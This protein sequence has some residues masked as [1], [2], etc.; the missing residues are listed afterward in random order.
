MTDIKKTLEILIC[1]WPEVA[2]LAVLNSFLPLSM[3]MLMPQEQKA[4]TGS[5]LIAAIVS[6]GF[7]IISILL[8]MGFLRTIHLGGARPQQPI[9]LLKTGKHFFWR[10]FFFS[11]IYS[12]VILTLWALTLSLTE[13]AAGEAV[14]V[15]K[16]KGPLFLASFVFMKF[17]VLVMPII[18]VADCSV[19]N[20]F[21]ALKRYKLLEQKQ[22]VY[23]YCV[24]VAASYILIFL[25]VQSD[26]ETFF[27]QVLGI[28]H[29][30]IIYLISLVVSVTAIRFVA[31]VNLVYDSEALEPSETVEE[32]DFGQ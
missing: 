32:T 27:S 22:L 23:L 6:F 13:P 14:A 19:L 18:I 17:I 29:Q 3:T 2:L 8:F 10:Y 9:T 31:S 30:A 12:T 25:P 4:V 24:Q 28:L 16:Q 15:W 20:A 21:K 26:T 7:V 11:L 1:R 5:A